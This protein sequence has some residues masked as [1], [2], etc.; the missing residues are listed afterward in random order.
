MLYD[1][2]NVVDCVRHIDEMVDELAKFMDLEI[3]NMHSKQP[4]TQSV[5]SDSR[6]EA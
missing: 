1:Q 4:A 6:D 5:S 3:R 2:Y